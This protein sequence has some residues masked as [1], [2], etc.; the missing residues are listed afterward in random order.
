MHLAL[1]RDVV[2]S[3]ITTFNNNT[4]GLQDKTGAIRQ[5]L[6]PV[7]EDQKLTKNDAEER[8]SKCRRWGLAG[9]GPSRNPSLVGYA[10]ATAAFQEAGSQ[11]DLSAESTPRS[12][13]CQ[14]KQAFILT[15]DLPKF[16]QI[17]QDFTDANIIFL[18]LV[19]I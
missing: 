8:T 13:W 7:R 11:P 10:P 2:V 4:R 12:G 3:S 9:A 6:H 14:M 15:E 16:Y 18:E 19:N 5:K 17:S 1:I